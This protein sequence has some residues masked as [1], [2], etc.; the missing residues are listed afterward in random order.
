MAFRSRSRRRFTLLHERIRVRGTGGA[1]HR[2]RRF[3][4]ADEVVCVRNV[5]PLIDMP[6]AKLAAR[7]VRSGAAAGLVSVPAP[8][9]G[10]IFYRGSDGEYLGTR[11]DTVT[12]AGTEQA[13]FVGLAFYRREFL[14]L[15]TDRDFGVQPVWRRAQQCGM[16]VRIVRTR[17]GVYWRDVGT[18]AQLAQA[19]FDRLRPGVARNVPRGMV[20]DRRRRVAVPRSLRGVDVSRL[21]GP[22]WLEV[23]RVPAGCGFSTCV[24]LRG[25]RL[26]KGRHYDR[27][28]VTP[29]GEAGFE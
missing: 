9:G 29:W 26:R 12:E 23:P 28:V 1:L 10:T 25:S 16:S 21:R 27:V 15:L 18:V 4:G 11:D 20:V 19:H 14:Q 6:V 7:F 22:V 8:Q 24:V 13:F 3:F 5:E 17:S 2:A